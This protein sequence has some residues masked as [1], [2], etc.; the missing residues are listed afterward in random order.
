MNSS[1]TIS[2]HS[3]ARAVCLVMVLLLLG[4][5]ASRKV[6]PELTLEDR[7]FRAPVSHVPS[8]EEIRNAVEDSYFGVDD[9]ANN[10]N[11]TM[12]S[13]NAHF[14][15]YVFMPLVKTYNAVLIPPA[16]K[17]IS[18]GIDNL[19]EVPTFVNCVLQGKG[20]KAVVTVGRFLVNSTI[21]ILGLMDV[22]SEMGLTKHEEDFG[23]T[24]GVWGFDDGPYLVLPIL[25]PSNGRD[26]IGLVPDYFIS[27]YEMEA[28]Y[29]A[30]DVKDKSSARNINSGTRAINARAN[31]PFL[32]YSTDTPFEYEFV[33]FLYTKKRELDVQK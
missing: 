8:P 22:A 21:G 30:A 10:F 28:I 24:L 3:L 15:K 20:K 9:P 29:S 2:F 4:A 1:R 33:R 14:D 6:A 11:R 32:Y 17:G 12:Y 23:Q 27:M 25:G 7:Q 16:R 5:C 13:F 19:N 26:A 18:N 31:I